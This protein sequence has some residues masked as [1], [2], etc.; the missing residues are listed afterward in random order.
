[1]LLPRK[2]ADL[3]QE[4]AKYKHLPLTEIIFPSA[5]LLLAADLFLNVQ[6]NTS[7]FGDK[8]YFKSHSRPNKKLVL[9]QFVLKT[10]LSL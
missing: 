2:N 4:D 1:L 3:S 5:N 7:L 8:L 6:N 9:L 10:K